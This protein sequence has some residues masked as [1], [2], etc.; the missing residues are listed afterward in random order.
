[1]SEETKKKPAN[2]S[3][4]DFIRDAVSLLGGT[5]ITSTFLMSACGKEVES[6]KQNR[7]SYQIYCPVCSQELTSLDALKTHYDGTL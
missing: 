5:A 6:P 1:M 4:R 2:I 3:R 7:Y